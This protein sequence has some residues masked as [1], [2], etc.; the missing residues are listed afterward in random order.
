MDMQHFMSAAAMAAKYRRQGEN[1]DT[2]YMTAKYAGDYLEMAQ[3]GAVF[4]SWRS[5]GY[6]YE[7][8]PSNDAGADFGAYHYDPNSDLSLGQQVGNYLNE[9][10]GPEGV[11]S[12]NADGTWDWVTKPDSY[13]ALPAEADSG[14]QPPRNFTYKPFSHER[15]KRELRKR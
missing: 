2:A 1:A 8:L 5:S 4:T 9:H 15:V 3:Y 14:R 7:D 13:D 11:K 12:R 6:S 10:A